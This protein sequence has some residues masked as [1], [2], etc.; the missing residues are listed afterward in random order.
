MIGMGW[1]PNESAFKNL[2]PMGWRER[3]SGQVLTFCAHSSSR[4]L[5]PELSICRT[6][7]HTEVLFRLKNTW[8]LFGRAADPGAH[9]AVR[10]QTPADEN[11]APGGAVEIRDRWLKKT[12]VELQQW[13]SFQSTFFRA[14]LFGS[15]L[16]KPFV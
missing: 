12:H 6:R 15:E 9:L 10:L 8:M 11:K 13:L 7:A 14:V 1:K 4:T 16:R 3:F 5:T 2:S